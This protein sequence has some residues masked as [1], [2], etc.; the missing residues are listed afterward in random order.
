MT[1]SPFKQRKNDFAFAFVMAAMFAAI[2]GAIVGILDLAGARVGVEAAKT[3]SPPLALR[4]PA[5][6][7]PH[8]ANAGEGK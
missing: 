1:Y 4:G 6:Q 3:Q 7:A 8:V 2:V 5:E